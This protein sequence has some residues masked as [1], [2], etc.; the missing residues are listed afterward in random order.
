MRVLVPFFT[1]M[2]L[3]GCAGKPVLSKGPCDSVTRRAEVYVCGEEQVLKKCRTVVDRPEW[4]C[5]KL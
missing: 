1:S 4:V 5:D 3:C 2:I